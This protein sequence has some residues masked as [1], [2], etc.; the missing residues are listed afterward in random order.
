MPVFRNV[1][2]WVKKVPGAMIAPSGIVSE[3]NSALIHFAHSVAIV[4]VCVGVLVGGMGVRVRVCVGVGVGRV[5]VG[6]TG[7]SV[8]FPARSVLT[9]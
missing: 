2:D 8:H 7:V 1:H 4:G 5:A 9:A 3:T 6:G